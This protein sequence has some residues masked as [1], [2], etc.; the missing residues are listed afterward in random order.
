MQDYKRLI[1]IS[2]NLAPFLM[3]IK[4]HLTITPIY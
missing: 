2:C 4:L 1:K 3:V